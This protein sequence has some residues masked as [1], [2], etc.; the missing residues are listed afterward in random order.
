MN[1]QIRLEANAI[2]DRFVTDGS[3]FPRNDARRLIELI[4]VTPPSRFAFKGIFKGP[5][6][7]HGRPVTERPACRKKRTIISG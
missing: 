6:D 2:L 7:L 3:T 1:L 5:N 4:P